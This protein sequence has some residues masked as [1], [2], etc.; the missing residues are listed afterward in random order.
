[1]KR[2]DI[3]KT[4]FNFSEFGVPNADSITKYFSKT[5]YEHKNE[6]ISYMKTSGKEKCV[7][8]LAYDV[9]TGEVIGT[10]KIIHDN[11]YSWTSYLIYYIEKYNLKL[12]DE[13][14]Q[15]VLS[16]S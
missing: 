11:K 6:V 2:S 14:I 9:V 7:C 12:N 16:N 5:P 4:L 15:H 13:F 10:R 3:L 1:M 8:G